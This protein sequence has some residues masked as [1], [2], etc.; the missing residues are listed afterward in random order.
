[1]KENASKL[2]FME[3]LYNVMVKCHFMEKIY[4]VMVIKKML[5]F[6]LFL[7][8]GYRRLMPG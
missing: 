1:M 5:I 3:K 2:N 4:N 6:V 7:E 8:K